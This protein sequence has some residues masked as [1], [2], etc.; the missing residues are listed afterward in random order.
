MGRVS[1][2]NARAGGLLERPGRRV[3]HARAR[4]SL[5]L[6][7]FIPAV[8]R[9]SWDFSLD[10]IWNPKKKN[11]D[12]AIVT[13]RHTAYSAYV[14]THP[15]FNADPREQ[16]RTRVGEGRAVDRPAVPGRA[17]DALPPRLRPQQAPQPLPPAGDGGGGERGGK[18]GD[19]ATHTARYR[20]AQRRAPA[21]NVGVFAS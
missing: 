8:N 7:S 9:S 2:L 4:G 18:R 14:L 10:M 17:D 19:V 16:G 1:M 3:G 5:S 11:V 13:R 15:R 6:R 20:R 21:Q 12:T